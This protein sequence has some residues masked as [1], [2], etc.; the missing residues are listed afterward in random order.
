MSK[1]ER[2]ANVAVALKQNGY[3]VQVIRDEEHDV[4]DVWIDTP[5]GGMGCRYCKKLNE[6][7]NVMKRELF[8]N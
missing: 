3:M 2:L 5:S 6:A 8:D 4:T 7:F 1:P